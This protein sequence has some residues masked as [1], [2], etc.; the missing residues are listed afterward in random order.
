MSTLNLNIPNSG[1]LPIQQI[2]LEEKLK[3]KDEFGISEWMKL[4][5]S[6]LEA[7]GRYQFYN[8]LKLK[9]NYEIIN[10]RFI[11]QH[12]LDSEDYFDI[13]SAISQEFQLPNYLKHYDITTKAVNLLLGE[14]L[15]RPDIFRVVAQDAD[16]TNEKL[17][18]TTELM[19]SYMS[20]QV[21][22]EI[23]RKL[24]S[25]GIDPNRDKF[26]NEEEQAQYQ[27]FIQQKYQ[28]L[29]PE[30]I[31][32]FMKYDYRTAA[33]H[34]GQAVLSADKERFN[35][36][37]HE[38]TEFT[39][40]LVA[41]RCF[42]H[43]YLT[44]T[45]YS[46]GVWN[47]LNTFYHQSPEIRYVED[48]DYVGRTF[49]MSKAQI[50][51]R[52]GW[53][54][55]KKQQEALYPEW[56][57]VTN[58]AG[59]GYNTMFQTWVYP[60]QNYDD[61]RAVSDAVGAA[62]GFNP[63]DRTSLSSVPL[64]N[65]F[66]NTYL[67]NSYAFLQ[68]DLVQ[69]TEGYWMSQRKL[70]YLTFLDP[71]T[72]EVKS[73]I[74]DETFDPKLFGIEELEDSTYKEAIE[75]PQ[76]NT[77]IWF[78]V[79]QPWQG[80]K[81]NENHLNS[82]V[83]TQHGR[84]GLYIDIRPC[85]FQ[86][87]GDYNP[88]DAKL[89][90]CGGVFNNRNGRSMSIVD[91]LKPYQVYYNAL[92]NQAYGITQRN[93]GKFFLMD[94]N[95]LPSLKDWGG[96]EAY[97]KFMATANA[98]G[99]GIVDTST[100]NPNNKGNANFN[101]YQVVDLDES[102]KVT[103]LINLAMLVEQ[104]G[105]LQ[106]GITPQRQGQTQASETAQGNQIAV[107]NSYAITETYFENYYNY[108][109]RRL[110]MHLDIAQFCAVKQKD[111]TLPYITSDLGNAWINITGT[112]LMLKDLA[113]FPTN[114][115]ESA[116][117]KQIAEELIL[118]NNQS[119]IP[120]SAL[121]NIL[122]YQSITDMQKALEKAEQDMYKQKQEEMKQAREIEDMKLQAEAAEKQKDREKDIL[123]AQIK[124]ETDLNKITLQ[125]IANESSYDPNADLTDKLIAQK[126]IALKETQA[127]AQNAF[128]QMQLTN[129]MLDSFNKSKLEKEK[130]SH[131]KKIK[132][133]EAKS[134]KEIENQK[135]AQIEAQNKNQEKLAKM[136]H[137]TDMAIANKQLELKELEKEMKLL[138]MKNTEKKSDLELQQAKKKLELE[139]QLAEL[140]AKSIEKITE[141]KVESAEKLAQVKTKEVQQQSKLN[142]KA[143]EQEVSHKMEQNVQKHEHRLK[144]NEATHKQKLKESKVK[145][146]PKAKK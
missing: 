19:L 112:E 38:K 71:N 105:F 6:G 63:L 48:G 55:T 10:G 125:G 99:V 11:L 64:M 119:N 96:E 118:K 138:D 128:Q 53:R 69:A 61:F 12:Y 3:D 49:Y 45:G 60:F 103:R 26:K 56:N 137:E 111:I 4:N 67:G 50:I 101:H 74:V 110:R 47:P 22:A 92:M 13:A 14:Y 88:F 66:D 15:K 30:A 21:K 116:R 29:T 85:D 54:M 16:T 109:R 133:D 17:R 140:K 20:Q 114:A 42:T 98:L 65:E 81:I 70:G 144:E 87:K 129:Q 52:Y 18:T 104:Q 44:P 90:V 106:L 40:M 102:D 142:I 146:K 7:I 122:K 35:L 78:W 120:L 82:S 51:N 57:K 121:L 113:V 41:D 86:F 97:E 43:F 94:V 33:E 32:K 126:D 68:N 24:Q 72:E 75:N 77:I 58:A 108:K 36:R 25:Q 89:P 117:Q 95:I 124:A 31:D 127:N 23:D 8:N 84:K 73:K 107:N 130:L 59:T 46:M 80:I 76:P 134:K 5:L 135:L 143:K 28:E 141:V 83:D 132:Q 131:D 79:K 93:N 145:I 100:A 37:E 62:V 2:S 136:K 9:E 39:D 139:K 1:S 115:Q 34:W 123:I 91:L 27:E